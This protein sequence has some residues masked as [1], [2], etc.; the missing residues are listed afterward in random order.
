MRFY[1]H[2]PTSVTFVRSRPGFDEFLRRLESL[3]LRYRLQKISAALPF[4]LCNELRRR[5]SVD[6]VGGPITRSSDACHDK[7]IG[8]SPEERRE[9]DDFVLCR[10]FRASKDVNCFETKRT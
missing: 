7:H 4:P 5:A 8:T 1:D 2:P 3:G 6:V 9:F 10:V